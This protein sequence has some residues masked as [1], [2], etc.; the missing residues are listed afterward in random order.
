[1]PLR[2]TLLN[3]SLQSFVCWK[4]PLSDL[5][6]GPCPSLILKG[7]PLLIIRPNLFFCGYRKL[8]DIINAKNSRGYALNRIV[9][10][11]AV[12]MGTTLGLI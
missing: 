8:V 2:N 9:F 10:S 5:Y 1:M 12:N 6:V 11:G 7:Q 4:A 3:S